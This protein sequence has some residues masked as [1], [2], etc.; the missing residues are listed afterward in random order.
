[1]LSSHDIGI[2]NGR[3]AKGKQFDYHA[4]RRGGPRNTEHLGD[5]EHLLCFKLHIL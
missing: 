5:G 4:Q 2:F 1:M 3:Q